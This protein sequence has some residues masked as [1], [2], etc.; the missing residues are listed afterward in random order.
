[1]IFAGEATVALGGRGG[2]PVEA[3]RSTHPAGAPSA[4]VGGVGDA[5]S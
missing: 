4:A 3:A 1:M 5:R 2:R